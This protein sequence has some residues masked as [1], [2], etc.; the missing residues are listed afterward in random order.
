M[1]MAIRPANQ[2]TAEG[3]RLNFCRNTGP[4]SLRGVLLNHA[5]ATQMPAIVRQASST[6]YRP[7]QATNIVPLETVPN[8]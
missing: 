6:T 1:Q 3:A 8:S 2:A 5:A 4:R 7:I